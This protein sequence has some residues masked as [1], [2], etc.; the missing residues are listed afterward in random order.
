MKFIPGCVPSFDFGHTSIQ[1]VCTTR[2]LIC[3]ITQVSRCTDSNRATT[4]GHLRD[5]LPW[6]H[7][8]CHIHLQHL[9]FESLDDLRRILTAFS[10]LNSAEFQRVLWKKGGTIFKPLFNATSRQLS[11]F[12][13]TNCTSDFIAA[14]F[15][16][17]PPL[18]KYRSLERNCYP[19][20]CQED[21][22][23]LT[24]LVKYIFTYTSIE[25]FKAK[26]PYKKYWNWKRTEKKRECKFSVFLFFFLSYI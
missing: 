9:N 5:R 24:E 21:V 25:L 3:I 18:S 20:I 1:V 14:F 19:V 4:N 17:M 12:S 23:P 11:Q 13:L 6:F 2:L 7:L 16:A 22:A 8:I 10:V 26:P 15:W